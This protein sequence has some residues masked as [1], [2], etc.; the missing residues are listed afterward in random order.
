VNSLLPLAVVLTSALP[1]IAIFLIGEERKTARR[2]LNLLGALGKLALVAVL[3]VGVAR[4][5]DY[6]FRF[7]LLPGLHFLLQADALALLFATLSAVLWLVTTIYAIGYLEGEPNRAR[8]FGFFSLCVSATTG[9]AFAGNLLTFLVFY[10]ALTVSTYPLVVHR[11]DAASLAAGNRYLAFTLAGGVLVLL[12]TVWLYSLAGGVVFTPGGVLA[13]RGLPASELRVV[14]AVLIAGLAVK[15]AMVP[16]HL[17]LPAAM[18]AP[19]PVSALL[20]AVAV[21]KAGAFGV[22]R[23]VYEVYGIEHCAE[24]GL[25]QPLAVAASITIIY[26]SLRALTQTELKKLLAYSTVSQ[27]SYIV[28]GASIPGATATLG[29]LIHLAH[30]GVMKITLFFCAGALSHACGV[31]KLAELRGMGSRMPLTMAAFTVAALGMIGVPPLAGF[32]SKWYLGI[33]AA[34]AGE[35]WAIGVLVGS[36]LLNAAYFLPIIYSVWFLPPEPGPHAHDASDTRENLWLVAPALFTAIL[37]IT[38]GLMVGAPFSV[39]Q[40]AE[41]IVSREYLR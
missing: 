3:L 1:G 37:T 5:K 18:V 35:H 29:G 8:F 6:T 22:V 38:L 4:D 39:Q 27:V 31:H 10:E 12:G 26:G 33:G 21:V 20:H 2:A 13:G 40:W 19:A 32:V 17:W 7:E 36:T 41:I 25:L 11:G 28:L 30:Q 24:L 16:L 15:T 9:I 34:A 23:V 14:F